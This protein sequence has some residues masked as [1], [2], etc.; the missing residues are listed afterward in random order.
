MFTLRLGT[1]GGKRG[2]S[3]LKLWLAL[4]TGIQELRRLIKNCKYVVGMDR[5]TKEF[6]I[7]GKSAKIVVQDIDLCTNHSRYTLWPL[8]EW[9]KLDD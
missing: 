7:C 6:K 4:T 9:W 1:P 5:E 3:F 2:R 8:S